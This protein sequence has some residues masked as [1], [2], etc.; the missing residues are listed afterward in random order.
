MLWLAA[1]MPTAAAMLLSNLSYRT[2]SCHG[3]M[4]LL[5]GKE[6][7]R[8]RRA[9]PPP[10]SDFVL[11]SRGGM[12]PVL[13]LSVPRRPLLVQL[14]IR[15]PPVATI[16]QILRGEMNRS[17]CASF[18]RP[19]RQ[20]QESWG[21]KRNDG[22]TPFAMLPLLLLCFFTPTGSLTGARGSGRREHEAA[23]ELRLA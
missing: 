22:Q 15:F 11:P 17:R 3:L 2:R 19:S 8:R 7:G 13:I 5:W 1:I 14:W 16:A 4:G 18:G 6:S 23:K 9:S 20:C 10:Q 12:T 21:P